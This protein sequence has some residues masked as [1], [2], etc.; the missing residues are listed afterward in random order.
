VTFDE[1]QRRAMETAIYPP[2]MS[3][4]YPALGLAGEVGELCGTMAKALR[5]AGGQYNASVL[6]AIFKELGDCQWMLAAL[7]EGFG[8]RLEDVAAYNLAKLA[9]RK[10]RGTLGGSGDDR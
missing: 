3:V 5:D 9:D 4:A 7:A 6:D 10:A 2:E 8:W 1:Y